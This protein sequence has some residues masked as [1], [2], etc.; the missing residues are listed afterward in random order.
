MSYAQNVENEIKNFF[1]IPSELNKSQ[2][3]IS[4]IWVLL[5][6]FLALVGVFNL[7]SNLNSYNLLEIFISDVFLLSVS[8]IAMTFIRN[9]FFQV[10]K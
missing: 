8:F 4:T 6:F 5:G 10:W 9:K 1:V 7:M 2:K 3:I